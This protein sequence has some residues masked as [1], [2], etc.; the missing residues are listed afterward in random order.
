MESTT[1]TVRMQ[2]RCATKKIMENNS[3]ELDTNYLTNLEMVDREIDDALEKHPNTRRYYLRTRSK[4]LLY[5]PQVKFRAPK[6]SAK[7]TATTKNG[8]K[9]NCNQNRKKSKI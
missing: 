7:T 4:S 5:F 1:K 3:C 2:Q 9:N 8:Q 6:I